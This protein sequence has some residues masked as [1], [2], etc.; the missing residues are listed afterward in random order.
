MKSVDRRRCADVD[1]RKLNHGQ[2]VRSS[3]LRIRN[4]KRRFYGSNW[5]T[6]C[7]AWRSHF[8]RRRLY[9]S[10]LADFPVVRLRSQREVQRFLDRAGRA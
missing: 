2:L 7:V 8:R 1:L 3:A 9:P 10:L 6:N 5:T 4:G